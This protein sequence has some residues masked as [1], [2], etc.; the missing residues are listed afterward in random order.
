[1]SLVSPGRSMSRRHESLD[2]ILELASGESTA[3]YQGGYQ[4]LQDICFFVFR[5]STYLHRQDALKTLV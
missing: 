4:T 2:D 1:M 5:V 3:G